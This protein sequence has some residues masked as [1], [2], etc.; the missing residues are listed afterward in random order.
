MRKSLI[1][2]I[3]KLKKK[4]IKTKSILYNLIALTHVIG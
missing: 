3:N 4:A 1:L 2:P